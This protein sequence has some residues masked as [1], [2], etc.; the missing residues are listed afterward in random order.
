MDGEDLP[1]E[2]PPGLNS[3]KAHDKH[4]LQ[5][6]LQLK[7]FSERKSSRRSS[8]ARDNPFYPRSP[9]AAAKHAC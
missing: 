7:G 4:Y 6:N 1:G 2:R 5:L 9:F 8:A 3:G